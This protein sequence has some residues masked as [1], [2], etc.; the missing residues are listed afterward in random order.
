MHRFSYRKVFL[1]GAPLV[2]ATCIVLNARKNIWETRIKFRSSWFSIINAHPTNT[3][4]N[5]RRSIEYIDMYSDKIPDEILVLSNNLFVFFYKNGYKTKIMLHNKKE[6]KSEELHIPGNPI[7][8]AKCGAKEL[9]I[10]FEDY[11]GNIQLMFYD[12]KGGQHRTSVFKGIKKISEYN[13]KI[14]STS[15][16]YYYFISEI[17]SNQISQFSE[18]STDKP[19]QT[20]ELDTKINFMNIIYGNLYVI[21]NNNLCI[22]RYP[23]EYINKTPEILITQDKD[24]DKELLEIHPI[25]EIDYGI[26]CVRY[27]NIKGEHYIGTLNTKKN[28]YLNVTKIDSNS[29]IVPGD[30]KLFIAR[31]YPPTFFQNIMALLNC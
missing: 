3:F 1:Y 26:R 11:T 10:F 22:Y 16:K 12:I 20:F 13:F 31:F 5:E 15:T 2:C 25:S 24:K 7:S 18:F 19:K 28:E 9:R 17:N 21:S 27:K 6:N 29:L 4:F 23:S 30:N 14:M 8:L